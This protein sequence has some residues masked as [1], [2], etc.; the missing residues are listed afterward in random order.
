MNDR[1][2]R[3]PK[4]AGKTFIG[5]DGIKYEGQRFIDIPDITMPEGY[6]TTE[7]WYKDGKIHGKPAIR[8]PD[9]QAEEWHDGKFIQVLSLPYNQREELCDQREELFTPPFEY[10]GDT[11]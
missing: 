4:L 11:K 2:P 7:V 3:E 1:G 5:N 9:G 6:R 10:F 8:Y